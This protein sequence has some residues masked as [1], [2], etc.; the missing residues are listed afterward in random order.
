[1]NEK[2]TVYVKVTRVTTLQGGFWEICEF[3]CIISILQIFFIIT[4][5]TL[6]RTKELVEISIS[7]IVRWEHLRCP[8]PQVSN[9]WR[10]K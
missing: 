9:G 3:V 1:M 6:L 4:L 5:S 7:Q 2:L 8:T 10:Q